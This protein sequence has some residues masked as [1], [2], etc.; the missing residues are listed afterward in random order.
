M[1]DIET[2]EQVAARLVDAVRATDLVEEGE[3]ADYAKAAALI[4]ADRAAVV[5]RSLREGF[6]LA[7]REA[8]VSTHDGWHITEPTIDWESARRELEERIASLRAPEGG[9]NA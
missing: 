1:S 2:P 3:A 8:W 9:S 6:E 7:Q 5:E 4:A